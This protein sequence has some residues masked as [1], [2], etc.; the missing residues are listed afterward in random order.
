MNRIGTFLTLAAAG[1]LLAPAANAQDVDLNAAGRRPAE[2]AR[3]ESSK[4]VEVLEWIGLEE[5]ATVAD[6]MAGT[7]YHSWIF[8]QWVGPE[9]HVYSQ[10]SPSRA[11]TLRARIDSGDLATGYVHYVERI[12]DLSDGAFDLMFTDR[13]YHDLPPDQIPTVLATI[14]SKLKPGGLFV[15]IDA[16]ATEGRDTKAHRIA[17]DVI[18]EEVTAAGFELVEKSEMMANP[19]DD[20]VGGD[21]ENRDSL[22]RSLIKFQKPAGGEH[23]EHEGHGGR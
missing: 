14:Q 11:D 18:V 15:V 13:N 9:G 22:D 6:L 16:R 19:A 23:G 12:S 21:F 10:S 4:P 1:A 7:G 20:H 2:I 5:G 17:D 3:D 8:A